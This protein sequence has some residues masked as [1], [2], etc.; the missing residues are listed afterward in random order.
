MTAADQRRADRVP[1]LDNAHEVD[2][3]SATKSNLY[4]KPNSTHCECRVVRDVLSDRTIY[5][6]SLLLVVFYNDRTSNAPV[7]FRVFLASTDFPFQFIILTYL[8]SINVI[9]LLIA[10]GL[11]IVIPFS[12]KKWI[13]CRTW[14]FLSGYAGKYVNFVVLFFIYLPILSTMSAYFVEIV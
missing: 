7:M 12:N 8:Y 2:H 4:K 6:R 9:Q 13:L 1:T 10:D 11:F 3:R 14:V 5:R